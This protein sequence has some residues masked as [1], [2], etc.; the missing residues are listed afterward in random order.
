MLCYLL[1]L[2]GETTRP[3]NHAIVWFA[4][5]PKDLFA[6]GFL[7]RRETTTGLSEMRAQI[8]PCRTSNGKLRVIF[9]FFLCGQDYRNDVSTKRLHGPAEAVKFS[10]IFSGATHDGRL[11]A[12]SF[13]ARPGLELTRRLSC[14]S[15]LR[16]SQREYGNRDL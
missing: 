11:R 8:D 6:R 9:F 4:I 5:T 15:S 12:S 10:P 3:P 7:H 13:S 1:V 14:A 16:Y 2:G